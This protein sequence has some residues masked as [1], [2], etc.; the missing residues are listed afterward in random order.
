MQDWSGFCRKR[1]RACFLRRRRY[2]VGSDARAHCVNDA[3]MIVRAC[4]PAVMARVLEIA[5]PPMATADE[6]R[7]WVA[8]WRPSYRAALRLSDAQRAH[9]K[10]GGWW[11]PLVAHQIDHPAPAIVI[12]TVRPGLHDRMQDG[13]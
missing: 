12:A 3:R 7:E 11:P 1:L 10:L 9:L 4:R 6:M 2:K 13:R 5:S 8:W